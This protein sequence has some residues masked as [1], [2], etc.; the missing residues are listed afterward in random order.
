[1]RS[2][3]QKIRQIKGRISQVSAAAKNIISLGIGG[4][5]WLACVMVCAMLLPVFALPVG[6][7]V[8]ISSNETSGEFEAVNE[9]LPLW[10]GLWGDMNA[11]VEAL[12]TPLRAENIAFG[13]GDDDDKKKKK[14]KDEKK[15]EV[16]LEEKTDKMPTDE[17]ARAE[18]TDAKAEEKT[19]S[20]NTEKDAPKTV[21]ENKTES[22][23]KPKNSVAPKI[24]FFNQLPDDERASIYSF[25]NNV[26]GAAA[27]RQPDSSNDA[28]A[29]SIKHRIGIANFSFGLPLA[30]LSGRG[31]DAGVGMTY[32]SRTWNKSIN[33]NQDDHYTY[34]V[35]DSWIAPGFSTGFGYLESQAQ[36]KNVIIDPPNNN[37]HTEIVPLGLTNSDGGRNQLECKSNVP[38]PGTNQLRCG[39]YGTSDGT[40]IE[41]P[42]KPYIQNP[43]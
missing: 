8:R 6:G 10:A 15:K 36:L 5:Q 34:D 1:M 31:I 27:Y 20:N 4:K 22:K 23:I 2:N 16:K 39:S 41:F 14:K 7:S 35:E 17:K 24:P 30:G 11:K 38:I 32:N 40:F 42:S 13:E 12:T 26:G 33:A 37:Y 21:A 19:V 25:E 43:G 9:K 3:N 28:A 29:T 18:N